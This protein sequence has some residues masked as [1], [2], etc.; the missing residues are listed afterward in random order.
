MREEHMLKKEH[1][2]LPFIFNKALRITWGSCSQLD[3]LGGWWVG[4]IFLAKFGSYVILHSG[5]IVD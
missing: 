5:D 4:T 3:C 2:C 1:A